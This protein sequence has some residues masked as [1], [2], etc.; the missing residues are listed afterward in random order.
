MKIIN[1]VLNSA[2]TF[3]SESILLD[4][5]LATRELC[6]SVDVV[7]FFYCFYFFQLPPSLSPSLSFFFFFFFFLERYKRFPNF[8]FWKHSFNLDCI[9]ISLHQFPQGQNLIRVLQAQS[10]TLSRLNFYFSMPRFP[11]CLVR[12][13][14]NLSRLK[15]VCNTDLLL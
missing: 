11:H 14:P 10:E 15:L 2:L 8:P 3:N 12:S 9:A 7:I 5:K 13:A 6:D 1:A 4:M